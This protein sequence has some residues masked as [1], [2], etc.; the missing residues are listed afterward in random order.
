[1]N[2][3]SH[4]ALGLALVAALPCGGRREVKAPEV[5]WPARCDAL[6]EKPVALEEERAVG[7]VVALRW[8][9][10]GGGLYLDAPEGS[11]EERKGQE[12]H[13]YLQLVGKNLGA[14]SDRPLL[15]W[16]FGVLDSSAVNSASAPGGYVFITRGLLRLVENEAQLAGVLGHEIG[17]VVARHALERYRKARVRQCRAGPAGAASFAASLRSPIGYLELDSMSG[18]AIA[19]LGDALVDELAAG[20]TEAEEQAA[21]RVAL[22]LL[23]SAGYRPKEYVRLLERLTEADRPGLEH[24]ASLDR[25]QGLNR[26]L[27]SLKP[28]RGSFGNAD[29][30]FKR[31]VTVPLKG[32]LKAVR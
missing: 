6:E 18:R 23:I 9:L 14:L 22:E 31:Y 26:F 30:P 11:V 3:H 1:M 10:D 8:L 7:G 20:F 12:L 32:E 24:P 19:G 4:L 15:G 13:R 27:A 16:T 5:S 28:A 25:W 2:A 29:W 17:H 21:D